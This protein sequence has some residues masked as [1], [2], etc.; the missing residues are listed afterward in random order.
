MKQRL[1]AFLCILLGAVLIGTGLGTSGSGEIGA[2]ATGCGS[3]DIGL[4]RTCPVAHF[5]FTKIVLGNDPSPPSNWSVRITSDCLDPNTGLPVDQLV[6]VPTGGSASS[7]DLFI[8][9]TT[10]HT[11]QC[12]YVFFEDPLPGNCTSVFDPVSPQTLPNSDGRHVV[13]TNTCNQRTTTA[14]PTRT[15]T[16][17]T[18]TPTESTSVPV[19]PS[20]S[21][22]PSTQPIS[23][24][25]PREQ[26]RA[27]VWIGVALCVLGLVLLFAGRRAGRHALRR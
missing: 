9:T 24:T 7:G 5:T 11:M 10:A 8:Y 15:S 18:P 25:G 6:T 23:N 22:V 14:P 26:V 4:A 1:G 17:P 16:A 3:V 12:G 19:T 27:S 13:V 20:S 21:A 2:I